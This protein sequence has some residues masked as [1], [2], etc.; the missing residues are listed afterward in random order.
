[1]PRTEFR[2]I[3]VFESIFVENNTLGSGVSTIGL[4]HKS[5]I[6]RCVFHYPCTRESDSLCSNRT[7]PALSKMTV[8]AGG[9]IV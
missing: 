8:V 7:I 6:F 4:R 5:K 3:S 9:K 2:G 1:M